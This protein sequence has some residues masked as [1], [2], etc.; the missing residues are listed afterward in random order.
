MMGFDY[1]DDA[2]LTFVIYQVWNIY[3]LYKPR[4]CSGS[5]NKS[6]FRFT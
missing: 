3:Q 2:K 1:Y 5:D 6:K 4:C